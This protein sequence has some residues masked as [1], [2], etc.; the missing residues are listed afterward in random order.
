M[1]GSPLALVLETGCRL[2]PHTPQRGH[3]RLRARLIKCGQQ[4]PHPV[5]LSA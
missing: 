2:L 5:C 4:P 3:G 1:R